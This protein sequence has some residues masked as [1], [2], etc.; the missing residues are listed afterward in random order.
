MASIDK[1]KGILVHLHEISQLALPRQLISDV[2]AIN[3]AQGRN[4]K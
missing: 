1:S 2:A 3:W 4:F